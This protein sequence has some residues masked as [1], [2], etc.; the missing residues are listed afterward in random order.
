MRMFLQVL[1]FNYNPKSHWVLKA[2]IHS[3]YIETLLAEFPD[4]CIINTHR[5]PKEVVV[6]WTKFQM[7]MLSIYCE[8]SFD[9]T[10]EFASMTRQMCELMIDRVMKFRKAMDPEQE[11][12]KF[13]DVYVSTLFSI[14]YFYIFFSPLAQSDTGPE[15]GPD[16]DR[17]ADLQAL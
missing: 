17:Q 10:K 5:D 7:Q 2:P 15:Q 4:A 14:F 11:R 8:S 12:K 9:G 6:S 16:R 13:V 3:L 1:S